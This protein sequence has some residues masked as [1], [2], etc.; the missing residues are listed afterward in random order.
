LPEE[1]EAALVAETAT[2]AT[3]TETAAA[4]DMARLKSNRE[5]GAAFMGKKTT[6]TQNKKRNSFRVGKFY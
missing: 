2:E 1:E 5:K 4:E 6:T 3:W